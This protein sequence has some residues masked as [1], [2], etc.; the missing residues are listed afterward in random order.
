[1]KENIFF[2]AIREKYSEL[3]MTIR[4][5][6]KIDGGCS[7]KR[8]DIFIDCLTHVV[9]SELDENQHDKYDK[10]CENKR[11]MELFEDIGNR[12]IIVLRL[13]PD[14]YVDKDEEKHKSCFSYTKTGIIHVDK[15]EWEKRTKKFMKRFDYWLTHIPTK[16]VTIE[17]FFYNSI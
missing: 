9:I 16:E 1:L 8:P 14:S 6:K 4:F 15:K 17:K 13:N 5:D 12:P 11:I 3:E 2:E 10:I 7:N